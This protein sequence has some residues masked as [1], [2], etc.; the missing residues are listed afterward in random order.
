V[1]VL[2]VEPT[3]FEVSVPTGVVG[4]RAQIRSIDDETYYDK[5]IQK[6][7]DD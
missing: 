7:G 4:L 5:N 2:D 1:D 3:N 6:D